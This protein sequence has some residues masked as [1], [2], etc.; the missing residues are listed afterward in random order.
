[1]LYHNQGGGTLVGVEIPGSGTWADVD[2]NS[3]PDLLVSGA[4]TS[5]FLNQ[6]GGSF[7]P[8]VAASDHDLGGVGAWADYDIDGRLEF[9]VH[10][11][12]ALYRSS[13]GAPNTRPQP[14]TSTSVIL[15]RSGAFGKE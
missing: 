5:L 2:S 12:F 8:E 13:L 10:P 6:S 11:E 1:V 9:F 3:Y 14:P 7:S 15:S 4:S